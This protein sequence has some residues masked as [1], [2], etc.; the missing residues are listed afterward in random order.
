[1]KILHIGLAVALIALGG[2]SNRQFDAFFGT[3]ETRN[4]SLDQ[5]CRHQ[6]SQGTSFVYNCGRHNDERDNDHERERVSQSDRRLKRDIVPAGSLPNGIPLYAFN[7][8][9]GGPR[10]V[11][12]VAQDVLKVMPAAV[13]VDE[14]GFY[15][16]DYAMI[17]AR[18]VLAGDQSLAVVADNDG[19]RA[20]RGLNPDPT[21]AITE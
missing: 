15:R 14:Y 19:M 16:V 5:E 11:G 13:S 2:C 21:A 10:Y 6:G 20:E 18:M 9:W 3:S 17:G 4:G 7:Y 8:I 1:M 12:V